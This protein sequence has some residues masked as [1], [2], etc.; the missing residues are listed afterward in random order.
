MAGRIRLSHA[1]G[2][3]NLDRI[4]KG[5]LA[6]CL[7]HHL[8]RPVGR[9][10][11]AEVEGRALY[12]IAEIASTPRGQAFEEE[13]GEGIRA[14]ISPGFVLDRVRALKN[15]D[16]D[17][18]PAA[19]IQL[20]VE[21]WTVFEVSSTVAPRNE[22]ARIIGKLSMNT[23]TTTSPYEPE[24]VSTADVDTLML[25]ALRMA[26]ANDQLSGEQAVKT[27]TLLNEFDKLVGQGCDRAVAMVEARI[28]AGIGS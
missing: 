16:P 19:G 10:T 22:S 20:S 3:I 23:L 4:T 8:D 1:D 14:G 2:A 12:A 18:D 27:A 15:G 6:L 7:D 13:V 11:G 28:K 26:L 17:F 5:Q 24:L 9:I 25:R 21:A